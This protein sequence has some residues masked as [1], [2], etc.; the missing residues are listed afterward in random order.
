ME[1]DNGGGDWRTHVHV[2]GRRRVVAKT[3]ISGFEMMKSFGA[4]FTDGLIDLERVAARL[5]L[6]VYSVALSKGL[7]ICEGSPSECCIWRLN[8]LFYWFLNH[9]SWI[10]LDTSSIIGWKLIAMISKNGLLDSD[11]PG[12]HMKLCVYDRLSDLPDEMLHHVM[13]FL[14][15][16]EVSRTCVLSRRWRLLWASAP[17]L[18]I[19]IDKFANDRVRFSKFVDQF[20]LLRSPASLDTFRLHSFAID[21]ACNWIE[22]AIKHN[23]RVLE[24]TECIRWEPFY[25]EPQLIALASRFLKCL[26]LT[27]VTLDAEV[28]D[29]LNHACPALENLQLIRSFLEVPVI[30]SNSL[31]KLDIIHCSLLGDLVICAPN[32]ISL[33]FES[34]QCKSSSLEGSSITRAMV[35]LCDLSNAN[36]IELT[37][38]VRKVRFGLGFGIWAAM[39]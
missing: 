28:F 12:R 23:V 1:G 5:E 30:S 13:S 9:P 18:D 17:C 31:K 2:L 22:Y 36:N 6:R 8:L 10:Y 34:P 16:Q 19:S 33:H 7:N 35:T 15:A 21:R 38:F 25:L 4:D 27:N 39:S 26:K 29:P 11:S 3:S 24:F 20:L 37:F 32:L 14:S